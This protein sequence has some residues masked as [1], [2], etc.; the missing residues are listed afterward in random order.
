MKS[1]LCRRPRQSKQ[2]GAISILWS[3]QPRHNRL[4]ERQQAA[5][6]TPAMLDLLDPV[7]LSTMP[8][9]V[10][11]FMLYEPRDSP[12]WRRRETGA[13]QEFREQCESDGAWCG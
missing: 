3:N 11:A 12:P 10:A 5:A 1:T 7:V 13:E 4:L 6:G 8:P 2:A 9:R